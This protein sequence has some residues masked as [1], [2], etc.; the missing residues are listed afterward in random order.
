MGMMHDG[1]RYRAEIKDAWRDTAQYLIVIDD[2][3]VMYPV[4]RS[5]LRPGDTEESIRAMGDAAYAEF[6]HAVPA[7]GTAH[8]GTAECN[9]VCRLLIEGGAEHW[10]VV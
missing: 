9:T 7:T 5:D 2:G 1:P 3:Q 4:R 8:P 10:R 6:C